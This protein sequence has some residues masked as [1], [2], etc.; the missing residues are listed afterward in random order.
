M[1]KKLIITN[2]KDHLVAAQY[3]DGRCFGIHVCDEQSM[4]GNIYIG[5]VENVVKNLNCAF[6]E[7]QKGIKC[8]YS[9][10]ENKKHI[11][12]NKKNNSAVNI[13][14]LLLVR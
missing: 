12:L 13:G 1:D 7:I 8:F 4:V 5:R 10:E 6:I 11:F 3:D 2:V 9:L 14:D